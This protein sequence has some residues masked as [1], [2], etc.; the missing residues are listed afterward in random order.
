MKRWFEMN[1]EINKKYG[2]SNKTEFDK[3]DIKRLKKLGISVA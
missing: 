2:H 3:E 1:K